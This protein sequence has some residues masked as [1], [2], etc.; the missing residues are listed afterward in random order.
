MY[1]RTSNRKF[2]ENFTRKIRVHPPVSIYFCVALYW[3]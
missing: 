3:F 2:W 1:K